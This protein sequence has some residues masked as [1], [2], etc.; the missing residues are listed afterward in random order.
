MQNMIS[1]NGF[2]IVKNENI[3]ELYNSSLVV[4]KKF[5]NK[6]YKFIPRNYF[7][8][9]VPENFDL[10]QK[11]NIPFKNNIILRDYQKEAIDLTLK[12]Y[13]NSFGGI[14]QMSC[15]SG[16]TLTSLAIASMIGRKTLVIVDR[17]HLADQWKNEIEN[18]FENCSVNIISRTK[19]I[20]N[21]PIQICVS[22]SFLNNRFKWKDFVSFGLVIL[23]EV[24]VYATY[25]YLKM[26]WKISRRYILGLTAT[27]IRKDG[28]EKVIKWFVG[29]IVFEYN[30][31]YLGAKPIVIPIHYNCPDPNKYANVYIDENNNLQVTKIYKQIMINDP[32]R[33]SLIINLVNYA[34]N[35]LKKNKILIVCI[36][37]EQVNLLYEEIKKKTNYSVG[38]FLGAKSNVDKKIQQKALVNDIIIAIRNLGAQSL[39]IPDLNCMILASSYVPDDKQ[40]LNLKQLIGRLL[41]KKHEQSPII[42]DVIDNFTFFIKQWKL[43]KNWYITNDI[44]INYQKPY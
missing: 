18:V 14:L 4:N 25:A 6:N 20:T 10:G 15:G 35:E 13:T 12:S 40:S 39:N 36:F 26:F 33:L 29:D 21:D 30:N 43:R 8:C 5:G 22:K 27:L 7:K 42:I 28:L 24:H 9:L 3:N 1:A 41:R 31:A 23:D 37:R 11:V 19:K 44:E 32:Y 38:I 2:R 34:K 17:D 16:K